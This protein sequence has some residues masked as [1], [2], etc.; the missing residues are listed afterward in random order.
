ML[1]VIRGD[2]EEEVAF[3]R[4][5][6]KVSYPS[7]QDSRIVTLVF[8]PT[9]SKSEARPFNVIYLIRSSIIIHFP[10]KNTTLV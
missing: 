7:T 6:I 9:H 10:Q 3:T 5:T 4:K 2:E 1:N 8:K